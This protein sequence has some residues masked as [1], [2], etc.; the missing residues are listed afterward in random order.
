MSTR[1]ATHDRKLYRFLVPI[2]LLLLAGPLRA[3]DPP[4]AGAW[5]GA[6]EVP[7]QAVKLQVVV[8][9][10]QEGGAWKG[11]IDI[12]S[13]GAMGLPL[14]TIA[15]DG[16]RV[17]F[18]IA[19]VPGA[20]TFDGTISG[21]EIRGTFTQG[22]TSMPFRL[23]RGAGEAP[24]RPQTPQPPFPY[25]AEEV[26]YTNGDVKLAGTLT[27]PA[28]PGPFPAVVLISGSGAQD[29][30]EALLGHRPF[31]VLA[32]HLS[33]NGIAVLRTDD[34]GIGGS[35]GSLGDSTAA[36]FAQDALAAVRFLKTRPKIAADRIGLVGHSEGGTIAPLAASQSRD[37]AFVVLLAGTGVPGREVLLRQVELIDRAAGLPEDLIRAE[38]D[39]VRRQNQILVGEADPA[40]RAAKLRELLRAQ[41][42]GGSAGEVKASG[43]V[44]KLV[45]SQVAVLNS[46]WF[47]DYLGHDPRPA[48]RQV[49]VPALVLGGALDVQ[50]PPDQNLPEIEKALKEAGNRDVTVRQLPGLNHLFQ[51]A[52]TGN[53]S[54]YSTIETTIDPAVLDLVMRW[55]QE[56]FAAPPA[57]STT[58]ARQT[59][60]PRVRPYRCSQTG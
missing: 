31:L 56:R 16:S 58:R 37:V 1:G 2:G 6:I 54:E 20:P 32:D 46:P 39:R 50:V 7:V 15:V 34:R 57:A 8:R 28:G 9:L 14:E 13:Q 11:S 21:D 35:S 52:R 30:D 41:A 3:A 44:E 60:L 17:K 55:I 45:D 5:H 43:E 22:G 59:S 38:L 47:R 51:P 33:R 49:K 10:T 36:D 25:T 19:G 53:V 26:T 27:T 40:A 4:A 29:R 18:S 23:E 48:L 42:A 24:R 12:P